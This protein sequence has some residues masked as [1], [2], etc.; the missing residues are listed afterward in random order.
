[1][2]EPRSARGKEPRFE[3]M[4]Q[5]RMRSMAR[6]AA[7]RQDL[8]ARE[9]FGPSPGDLVT[10][11]VSPLGV[12]W[13]V[14]DERELNPHPHS[15]DQDAAGS[16]LAP[17]ASAPAGLDMAEVPPAQLVPV[18][19]QLPENEASEASTIYPERLIA[20]LGHTR[21]VELEA[22]EFVVS[23]QI[24]PDALATVHERWRQE[25][26][27]LAKTDQPEKVASLA[28]QD[29]LDEVILPADRALAKFVVARPE[30]PQTA[31]E[32]SP[33]ARPTR[34]SGWRQ[35]AMALAAM[36]A[37]GWIGGY[38]M[39]RSPLVPAGHTTDEAVLAPQLHW[40]SPEPDV[41]RG[42]PTEIE[43]SKDGAPVVLVVET[44]KPTRYPAYRIELQAP[45]RPA[46]QSEELSMQGA[47]EVVL[48]LPASHLPAGPLAARLYG[49]EQ[50]AAVL[51]EE[52]ELHVHDKH[53]Q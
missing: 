28:L 20:H 17:I 30:K 25:L 33:I 14:L 22:L 13:L 29:W 37:L 45:G 38:W 47:S 41:V 48:L 16:W 1:M 3:R 43:L 31:S 6:M 40:L 49:L 50:E 52:F 24:S 53:S 10:L 36:W 44:W 4:R 26:V 46:W 42:G 18:A 9:S 21:K 2:K 34:A 27:P 12:E 32:I 23:G 7:D 5:A 35:S 8:Q 39:A 19:L 11:G 15:Q 51:L